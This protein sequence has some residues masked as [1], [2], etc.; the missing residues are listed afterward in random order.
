MFPEPRF[1]TSG[2]RE[3]DGENDGSQKVRRGVQTGMRDAG[4]GAENNTVFWY[5]GLVTD[6]QILRYS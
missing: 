1:L 4:Q 3:M 5:H 6:K 2:G